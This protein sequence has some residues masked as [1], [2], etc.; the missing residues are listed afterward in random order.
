MAPEPR[1]IR[2]ESDTGGWRLVLREP[3][4]RLRAD[5]LLLEDYEECMAGPVRERHLPAVFVPLILNFGSPYR[6]LD[7]LDPTVSVECGSFTGGLSRSGAVT[8]SSGAARCVQVNLTPLGA[9]RF[10]GVPMH[11]LGDRVVPRADVLGRAVDRLEERLAEA[12]DAGARLALVESFLCAR[13][14][15]AAPARPDIAYA[16]GRLAETAG[17]LRIGMLAA[18]LGCSRK[19]LAEQF[20]DQLG[21]SPKAVARLLR[22]NRALR[23][24]ERGLGGAEVAFRCG[25]ADQAHFVKEFRRFSGS[26]PGA[27][28]P[29]PAMPSPPDAG[30]GAG[31]AGGLR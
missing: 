5:A 19:H 24:T 3:D 30:A 16:W 27:F 31:A 23:L 20:R 17:R 25:Y 4:A 6:L 13:L 8:E 15:D 29:A 18:E 7:A 11:E 1:V 2:H 9:R 28:A 22:F 21:L 10:L 26:T 14:A 12:P